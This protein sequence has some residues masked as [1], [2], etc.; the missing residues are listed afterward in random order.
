M[1]RLLTFLSVL[2]GIGWGTIAR[3]QSS[4]FPEPNLS[5][6]DLD[7]SFQPPVEQGGYV[8]VS[9]IA[10][11]INQFYQYLIGV[12]VVAAIVMIMIGG[13][14][15]TLAGGIPS[16]AQK[17]KE[18]ILNATIGLVLMLSVYTILYTVNPNLTVLDPVSL[19]VVQKIPYDGDAQESNVNPDE[20]Q[21]AA[22]MQNAGSETIQTDQAEGLASVPLIK[23]GGG[24]NGTFGY[25]KYG[26]DD[27]DTCPKSNDDS[28]SEATCCTKYG[29]SGCAPTNVA[30]VLRH[31]GINVSVPEIGDVA[32]EVGAR[33]CNQGTTQDILPAVKDRYGINGL[34]I[35][36]TET[37]TT[38]LENKFPLIGTTPEYDCWDRGGH[39]VVYTGFYE[40]KFDGEIKVGINDSSYGRRCFRAGTSTDL[41]GNTLT[42][43]S[44]SQRSSGCQEHGLL[45]NRRGM[46]GDP[47]ALGVTGIPQDAF[48]DVP[49]M[50]LFYKDSDKQQLEKLGVL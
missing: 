48:A 10:D 29:Y 24:C 17:A 13:A 47:P 45:E 16:Q 8:Y 40:S 36:D 35:Q 44:R 1:F 28:P 30:M 21:I 3:A 38:L 22:T 41:D 43:N 5:T 7:I 19:K 26:P 33:R 14:Q 32:V 9:Y 42:E 34:P 49:V 46:E 39:W 12:S 15:Y 37:A 20:G 6:P 27:M 18:R 23:Q 25:D 50:Y 2:A 31:H 4:K 11:F